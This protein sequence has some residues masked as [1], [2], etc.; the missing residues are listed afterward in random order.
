ML[1]VATSLLLATAS[2][3][4]LDIV[5]SRVLVTFYP[6]ASSI[7]GECDAAAKY[8]AALQPNGQWPDIVYNDT[9]R[10]EWKAMDHLSRLQTMAIAL[11]ANGSAPLLHNTSGTK[12]AML[13][14][15]DWWTQHNPKNPNWW[16]NQIGMPMSLGETMLMIQKLCTEQQVSAA[17]KLIAQAKIGM[18]GA[19][20]VWLARITMWRGLLQRDASMVKTAFAAIWGE[21]RVE[22]QSGDNIQVDWSFHQHGPQLLAGSYGSSFSS[23][24]LE[25]AS[26]ATGTSFGDKLRHERRQGGNPAKPAP[27][28]AAV[29]DCA[30]PDADFRLGRRWPRD[31]TGAIPF[32]C[33][34]WCGHTRALACTAG[35]EEG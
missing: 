35:L 24:L 20:M 21:V 33:C 18:T 28:R 11:T 10:S 7:K 27:R 31:H 13:L 15:L 8:A 5:H 23:D 25:L 4:D 2:A 29:D 22:H 1:L 30:L 6:A 19:N 16:F 9:S 14:A 32:R 17:A 3:D 34:A 12:A 26:E